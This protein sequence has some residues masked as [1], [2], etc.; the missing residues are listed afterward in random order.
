MEATSQGVGYLVEDL[1]QADSISLLSPQCVVRWCRVQTKG[2]HPNIVQ[3][4]NMPQCGNPW[5][6]PL[7]PWLGE[8]KEAVSAHA[9]KY[10]IS[11]YACS[12]R[13]Q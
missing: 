12:M 7:V 9:V 10:I 6:V 8:T 2:Q 11:C 13:G 5:Y 1:Y 3:R 4:D